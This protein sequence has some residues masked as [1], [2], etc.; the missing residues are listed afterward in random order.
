METLLRVREGTLPNTVFCLLAPDGKTQLT[1]PTRG[2]SSFRTPENMALQMNKMVQQ[3]KPSVPDSFV[4]PVPYVD[5]VDLA[6]NVAAS[7]NR[8]L[9]VAFGSDEEELAVLNS[10]LKPLVW[11]AGLIGQFMYASTT[12]IAELKILTSKTKTPGIFV[13]E[14]DE[15]GVSGKVTQH[16]GPNAGGADILAA[17]KLGLKAFTPFD[18]DHRLHIQNGYTVGIEWETV[19]PESD[20]MSVQAKARYKARFENR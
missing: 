6:L 7:D 5:R 13:V 15:F 20:P 4:S 19:V 9:I 10:K 12:D 1:R 18:K 17:L 16:V 3:Y 14:P 8:P 11:E 2:P